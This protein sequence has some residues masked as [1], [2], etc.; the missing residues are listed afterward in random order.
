M[1]NATFWVFSDTVS[2]LMKVIRCKWDSW[3]TWN[4]YAPPF[5][6]I[7]T[8]KRKSR[9]HIPVVNCLLR[10]LKRSGHM[11]TMPVTRLSTMQNSLSIPMVCNGKDWKKNEGKLV[12]NEEMWVGRVRFCFPPFAFHCVK[13]FT[14]QVLATFQNSSQ[15][16]RKK[17]ET[18]YY[19]PLKSI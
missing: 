7:G 4:T 1:P 5:V 16:K 2:F 13:F 11:S 9:M 15:N 18:V 8:P 14:F 19:L 3:R 6:T 10:G 12:S 17:I